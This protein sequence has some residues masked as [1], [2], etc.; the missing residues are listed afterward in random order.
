MGGHNNVD[1][2]AG[3]FNNIDYGVGGY[4]NMAR[5]AET[6]TAPGVASPTSSISQTAGAAAAVVSP[7]AAATP[8]AIASETHMVWRQGY[9]LDNVWQRGRY[10]QIH[11]R[12]AASEVAPAERQEIGKMS[13][14]PN[15]SKASVEAGTEEA[16]NRHA[17]AAAAMQRKAYY[18]EY[19]AELGRKRQAS[20]EAAEEMQKRTFYDGITTH[21]ADLARKREADARQAAQEAAAAMQKSAYYDSITAKMASLQSRRRAEDAARQE[22]GNAAAAV[23]PKA[24]DNQYVADLASKR[25]VED[26]AAAAAA[27]AM[28]RKAYNDEYVADLAIKR[29]AEEEA[30]KKREAEERAA[31]AAAE[32]RKVEAAEAAVMQRNEFQSRFRDRYN[33]Y[34]ADL[35]SQ[36]LAP[37]VASDPVGESAPAEAAPMPLSDSVMESLSAAAS[38]APEGRKIDYGAGYDPTNRPG[39]AK[40]TPTLASQGQAEVGKAQEEEAEAMQR[41]AYKMLQI[42]IQ[43]VAD[44]AIKRQAEEEARKKREAEERAAAAAAEAK[45]VEQEAAAAVQRKAYND[46]YVADLAIKRQ[47]E[48]EARKMREAEERAAAAAAEAKRVEQEAAAAVQRKAY[49][50]GYVAD[51]AIKR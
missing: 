22:R 36:I 16:E 37:A 18:D 31:A 25:Q 29:Q 14:A 42:G 40:A 35:A 9:Y 39:A 11:L 27:A 5:S 10:E 21:M 28:Q 17:E 47:A 50:D 46:E 45:R 7:P 4:N 48:E 49:N 44:L 20:E 15:D 2:G 23:Q 51:L 33:K 12:P 34:M 3:G 24:Y 6:A 8:S 38:I 1:Y 32:A 19:I 43:N 13:A 41:K 30:R 26:E